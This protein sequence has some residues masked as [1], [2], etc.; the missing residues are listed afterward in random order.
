[1]AFPLKT[2]N[3]LRLGGD[4]AAPITPS[5]S[6]NSAWVYVWPI[7]NPDKNFARF[8]VRR[9]EVET[10]F[11]E[12]SYRHA[13]DEGKPEF[14]ERQVLSTIEEVEHFVQQW[15]TDLIAFREPSIVKY[16]FRHGMAFMDEKRQN[17]E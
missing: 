9:F 12:D 11:S 4:I 8:F 13:S 10:L 1:M 3:R 17:L 15:V 14:D 6:R 2:L 5:R 16:R 7:L